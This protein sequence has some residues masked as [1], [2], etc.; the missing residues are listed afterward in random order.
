MGVTSKNYIGKTNI[1]AEIR[2]DKA[3]NGK[4]SEIYIERS[5]KADIGVIVNTDNKINSSGNIND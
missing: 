3:N 4:T 5:N 1:K 2:L